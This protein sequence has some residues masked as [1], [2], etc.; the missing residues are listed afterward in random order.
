MILDYIQIIPNFLYVCQSDKYKYRD[1]SSSEWDTW[2]FL[3]NYS[4]KTI[5]AILKDIFRLKGHINH[6]QFWNQ[7]ILTDFALKLVKK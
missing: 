4:N 5:F 7:D 2:W 3:T 6:H 1:I